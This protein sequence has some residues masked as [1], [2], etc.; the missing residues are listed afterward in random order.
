MGVPVYEVTFGGRP[1]NSNPHNPHAKYLNKRAEIYGAIRDW[2]PTGCIPKEIP[3]LEQELPTE[4][5]T[6]SYTYAQ[7]DKIQLESKR[8]LK[9]R[10]ESSPDATDALACTFAYPV[11]DSGR[12]PNLEN[13]QEESYEDTMTHLKAANYV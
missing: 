6:L 12:Y 1:D 2:L 7:E 9:R 4:M 3:N 10:G 11:A 13:N 5:A 8:D